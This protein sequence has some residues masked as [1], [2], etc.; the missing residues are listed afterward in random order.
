M[1]LPKLQKLFAAVAL[2]T[3]L[4]LPIVSLAAVTDFKALVTGVINGILKPLVPLIIALAVIVF[5]WG[6][7]K[8][9]T[10]AGDEKRRKEGRDFIIWG[11]IGITVMFSI[12]GLVRILTD[13]LNL[14][15]TIPTIPQW[16]S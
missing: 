1:P 3:V 2:V 14:G 12:W 9:I 4:L 11:L 16:P 7:L 6:V 10:A 13:T 15:N 8:F 5:L